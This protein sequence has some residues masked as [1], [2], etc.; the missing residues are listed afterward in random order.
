VWIG[1]HTSVLP[2]TAAYISN[3]DPTHPSLVH[4]KL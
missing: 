3:H 1:G 4:P 2:I